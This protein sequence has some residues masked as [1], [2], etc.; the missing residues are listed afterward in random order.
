M[1]D[2]KTKVKFNDVNETFKNFSAKNGPFRLNFLELKRV[3]DLDAKIS[4]MEY[5]LIKE[6]RKYQ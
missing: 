2:L 4:K 3:K 1:I 5:A 6:L